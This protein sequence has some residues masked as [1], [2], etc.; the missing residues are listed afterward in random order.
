MLKSSGL[1]T[2]ECSEIDHV[3]LLVREIAAEEV[4]RLEF[5]AVGQALQ[6]LFKHLLVVKG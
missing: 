2:G 6:G 4:A 5:Q 3:D 1:S